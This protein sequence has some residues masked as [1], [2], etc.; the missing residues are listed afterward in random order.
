MSGGQLALP[1]APIV[2]PSC[3]R[4]ASGQVL[5][6]CESL[7]ARWNLLEIR[8]IFLRRY[9]L[10]NVAIEMF[11]ASR[12]AV[13]LAFSDE[14]TVKKVVYQL[15]RVGVGVKY[16]LPQSRKTSLMTPRQ[17]FRH[18][19]MCIKWQKREISNFDYLMFLNTVAGRTFNDLSQYPV[20]PWIL[21]NYTSDTL[22]LNVAS[23]FRDLSK[24]IGALSESRRKF[25]NERYTS[26][27]DDS[28]P[29]FHYGT[30]YSTPAFTLNWL[31]RI[32]PF[33]SMYISLN[34]GKFDHPDRIFNSVKETW[35]HCQRDSHDVKELIPELYYLP[36]VFRNSNS[37]ELG[38]RDDGQKVEDVQ[39]PPWAQSPEHFV[40]MHRQAL[41]S[42]LVS[43]QLN[44]W[45]DLI[46]GYKQRGAEAVRAT[47]VFYHLTYE[48]AI[49]LKTIDNPAQVEAVEQQI[50]SFGQTPAQLLTEAHPPRHSVMSMAPTM[51]RRLEDDLCMIMKYISNSAVVSLAANTFHQLP[52]PTVVSVANNL[53]FSLNKWDNS[54]TYGGTQRSALNLDA[55]SPETQPVQLPLTADPQLATAS[56]AQ[57]IPKRHLGDSFDQRLAITCSNFVTT[58]DSRFI[59]ACGYPDYSF[60]VIDTDTGKV[61]QAVYGHGDVVTCIA[62]SETSLFS[63]CYVATGSMDC[64]VVLWHWNGQQGY[65]AGEY[66]QPGETPSPRSILTGHE[67]RITAL[68]VSAEHGLVIS[69]CEDGVV[70][71][72]TTAGD[73]LR[74]IKGK[75]PVTQLAMSRECLLFALYDSRRIVTYS[76][77]ARLLN[78]V[79]YDDR[80][81]CVT[82]TRDGEFAITGAQNGRI[83]IWRLFPLTKLYTYQA[84]DSAVR[85]VAVT[86]NHRFIL[87]GLDSGAIVVFNA[88]FNRW[89]YE[90]KNRYHPQK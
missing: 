88:D 10:Q 72:H 19:D 5:R 25:F 11:L 35:E 31:M 61:R 29:A 73:L 56:S 46:F 1:E 63:D 87:G 33:A 39:L 2:R 76:A 75:G 47:N 38:T 82:V 77:T 17:L 20:F 64:T 16:G 79:S 52:N 49:D 45:I 22:D 15:P 53:V 13:M 43:C 18:S 86:A 26:W 12:T 81:D 84:L 74:R 55:G 59:F 50:S 40:L 9:L 6:Y 36:E 70:L 83:V 62:R 42:D 3:R 48:G 66:N 85:S 78:E 27:S 80:I 65:I 60:R 69:G 57:P 28:I 4:C 21:T 7:H 58:T 30:H 54:Y 71:F 8:A 34:D 51:F 89:H 44:Q 24:P 41:E 32:E 23:N 67:A 90:Y 68:S 14:E 37:F